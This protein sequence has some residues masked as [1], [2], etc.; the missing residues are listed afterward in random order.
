MKLKLKIFDTV[1]EIECLYKYFP[2]LCEGYIYEGE[3]AAAFTVSPTEADIEAEGLSFP[4]KMPLG[5]LESTAIQRMVLKHMV[6]RGSILIHSAVICVD[7]EAYCFL[8][9]SGVGK[10]TH[11]RQW[12]THFGERAVVLNGD[13]PMYMFRDGR[14]M[15]CGVPWRGKEGWGRNMTAPVK[16]MCLLGRGEQNE[17]RPAT[18]AEVVGKLFHQLLMPKEAE[19]MAKFLAVVDRIAKEVPFYSMKCNISEEAAVTAYNAMSKEIK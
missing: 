5:M 7:G 15:V 17:I 12:M 16:A 10:S 8:A 6:E 1:V 2:R 18:S 14:L 3:E 9:Q 11:L 13:K 19:E 4:Q